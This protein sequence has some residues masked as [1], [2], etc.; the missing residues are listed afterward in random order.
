MTLADWAKRLD[1]D[2]K[3]AFIVNLLSQTN[4][5]LDDMLWVE[6]NI[7]TGHKTTIRTGLPQAYFRLMNQGIPTSKSTTAQITE[8]CGHM[9]AFSDIDEM[10]AELNGLDKAIRLSEDMAFI[11]GMNQQ[12]SNVLFYNNSVGT[13]AAAYMGL[14]PRYPSVL[15]TTAQTANNVLDAGGTAST[16][17]SVWLISWGPN[18]IHGIFPKGFR[19]GIQQRDLG[20]QVKY[21]ANTNPYYVYRTQFMWDAGLCVR[22]WRFAV[23]IANIDVTTLSGGTP[24]NLINLLIRAIHR[25]PIQPARA[26]NVYTSGQNGEIP[27]Q[28]GRCAFYCNRAVSTW[29]DIQA[30]N[31]S[32]VLLK[33]E[34]F[35]GKPVTTFRGIPIRTV[36]QIANNEARVV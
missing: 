23:R 30:V 29:L 13:G 17:T 2:G 26:G 10:L 12:M 28:L 34:E 18:Q 27:L 6:G 4:E 7:A 11:E 3:V 9:E 8:T 15:T 32:N 36:D 31:K 35:D 19:A 14:A 22:D 21:D 25:L 33:M 1:D 24:P 20:K 16:N 5:I